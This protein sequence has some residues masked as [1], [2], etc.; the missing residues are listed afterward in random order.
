MFKRTVNYRNFNNELKTKDLYFHLSKAD[1]TEI[2]VD[3]TKDRMDAAV[4]SQN[5]LA[6]M[7]ELR[8]FVARAIGARSEDGESFDKSPE[9]V[10]KLTS[11][12]AYDQLIS[13]LMI[14]ENVVTEFVTN[15]VPPELRQDLLKQL[16]AAGS[17]APDPFREPKTVIHGSAREIE[18]DNRPV[19]LQ[20][21]R[22]PTKQEMRG[23]SPEELKLLFQLRAELSREVPEKDVRPAWLKERRMPTDAE[24]AIM[25]PDEARSVAVAIQTGGIEL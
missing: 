11:S 16:E 23:I 5:K 8:K 24:Y 3:G 15:L 25:S 7:T 12:A 14:D 17:N 4:A 13:E 1:L 21:R 9:T 10:K 6:L 18:N 20:E 2:V 19:W 22:L